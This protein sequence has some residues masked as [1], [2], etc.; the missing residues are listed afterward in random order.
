MSSIEEL[1]FYAQ[2]YYEMGF[3]ISFIST[4]VTRYNFLTGAKKLKA[5]TF[6][7]ETFFTKRQPE[8]VFDEYPWTD[9][10]GFGLILGY[11]QLSSID[12]DGCI[13]EEV[14]QKILN[15][16]HLPSNYPWITRSGS[17][18]GYHILFRTQLPEKNW[19]RS[20]EYMEDNGRYRIGNIDMDFGKAPLNAYYPAQH[21][22]ISAFCKIEFKWQG[23]VIM[24]PSLHACGEQYKIFNR[25]PKGN[26]QFIDF[27]TLD[28]FQKKTCGDITIGSGQKTKYFSAQEL[29]DENLDNEFA[30][31]VS[32]R[33]YSVNKNELTENEPRDLRIQQISW[34]RCK[35]THKENDF[36]EMYTESC[37]FHMIDREVRTIIINGTNDSSEFPFS[38]IGQNGFELK[39]V[40]QE[41]L[42]HVVKCKVLV[43]A[44]L[45][46][47]IKIIEDAVH[48]CGLEKYLPNLKNKKRYSLI[49]NSIDLFPKNQL[50]KP[51]PT[52]EDLYKLIFNKNIIM[53]ENSMFQLFVLI[54]IFN[55]S[56][57]LL[58]QLDDKELSEAIDASFKIPN[59]ETLWADAAELLNHTTQK[60]K[61]RRL[62]V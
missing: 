56:Q 36:G 45:N 7:W 10:L 17:K 29:R 31:V 30:L 55:K 61:N 38:M 25:L 4:E 62:N 5:P 53:E 44:D 16:L 27:E 34:A 20:S 48:L 12:I 41:F 49:P 2:Y 46:S 59:W 22:S 35:I 1:K 19:L 40:I 21:F 43:G 54:H 47:D 14:L 52:L 15:F 23:H 8:E 3:N 13:D 57:P 42:E 18:G 11:N 6:E 37:R 33:S 28:I 26:P 51:T 39:P 60:T 24:P 32:I 58:T 9:A 50:T